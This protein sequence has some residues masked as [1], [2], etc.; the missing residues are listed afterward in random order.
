MEY[1]CKTHEIYKNM[2]IE[3]FILE[4]IIRGGEKKILPKRINSLIEIANFEN[5][6]KN[7]QY[8]IQNMF[9]TYDANVFHQIIYKIFEFDKKNF[10]GNVFNDYVSII[11]VFTLEKEIILSDTYSLYIKNISSF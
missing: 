7:V 10:Y 4:F 9:S 2:I 8:E 5:I 1:E 3:I 11:N 6:N